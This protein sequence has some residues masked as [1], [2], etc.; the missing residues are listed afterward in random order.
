MNIHYR[1]ALC[2]NADWTSEPYYFWARSPLIFHFILIFAY[3]M[4]VDG[5]L[6]HTYFHILFTLMYNSFLSRRR[7][8]PFSPPPSSF[9]FFFSVQQHIIY[10]RSWITRDFWHCFWPIP[11]YRL[12]SLSCYGLASKPNPILAQDPMFTSKLPSDMKTPH[13]IM[14]QQR[15]I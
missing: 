1:L 4:M 10:T 6:C 8:L 12:H 2:R 7:L 11:M 3:L 9:S 14:I 13:T 5:L 15:T